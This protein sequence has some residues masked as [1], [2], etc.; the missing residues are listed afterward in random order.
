MPPRSHGIHR[1]A[2]VQGEVQRQACAA[3]DSTQR[4]KP[5]L[6]VKLQ[7]D[8][9]VNTMICM[10]FYGFLWFGIDFILIPDV[11]RFWLTSF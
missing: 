1:V 5:G 7:D 10:D 4:Q 8:H 11:G 9:P 3:C 2:A 6:L